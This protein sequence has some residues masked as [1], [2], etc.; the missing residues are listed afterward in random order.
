MS[1]NMEIKTGQIWRNAKGEVEISCPLGSEIRCYSLQ[2]PYGYYTIPSSLF[3][4]THEF[5]RDAAPEITVLDWV[6]SKHGGRPRQI[7]AVVP[8][9]SN[10][11]VHLAAF[12]VNE[13]VGIRQFWS[14]YEPCDPP[15]LHK[16]LRELVD[17]VAARTTDAN[18]ASIAFVIAELYRKGER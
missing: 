9:G 16:A 14:R 12:G 11:N 7:T 17:L 10:G 6:V 4:L 8:Q 2:K 1:G 3:L 5:V 13:S 18:L 15:P